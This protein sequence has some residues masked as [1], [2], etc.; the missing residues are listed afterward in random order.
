MTS[1]PFWDICSV[2]WQSFTDVSGKRIGSIFKGQEVQ[3]FLTLE[4]EA[5]TFS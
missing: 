1:L 4:G 3:D 2:Q 5:D